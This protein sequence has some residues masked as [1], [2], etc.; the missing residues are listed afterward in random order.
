VRGERSEGGEAGLKPFSLREK[1]A[2]AYPLP[3]GEGG[4]KGRVRES[5]L[6]PFSLRE[7]GWDE[8]K[9]FKAL[10]PPGEGLG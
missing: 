5:G 4:P 10:P 1:T 6:K 3:P 9:G 2:P 7:K 8:G